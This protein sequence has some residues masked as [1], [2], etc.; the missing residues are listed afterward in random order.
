MLVLVEAPPRQAPRDAS[1][2]AQVIEETPRTS[3]ALL[4]RC[5]ETL[6]VNG[7]DSGFRHPQ[8]DVAGLA[9]P[10][11]HGRFTCIVADTVT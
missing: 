3:C 5:S 9:I 4:P 10:A 2:L 6:Q 11:I 8:D 1:E 7:L